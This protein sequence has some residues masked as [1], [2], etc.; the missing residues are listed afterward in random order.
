MFSLGGLGFWQNLLFLKPLEPLF[1][2]KNF[3]LTTALVWIRLMGLQIELYDEKTLE[4]DIGNLVG[5]FKKANEVSLSLSR[6]NMHVSYVASTVTMQ[7]SMIGRQLKTRI[8]KLVCLPQHE[9]KR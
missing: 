8:R 7:K 2:A 6:I 9:E 1:P 3:T 4:E 5:S